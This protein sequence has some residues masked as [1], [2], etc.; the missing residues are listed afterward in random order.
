VEEQAQLKQWMGQLQ[1][2]AAE[3]RARID[4]ELARQE[5]EEAA[6]PEPTTKRCPYCTEVIGIDAVKCKHC[7]EILDRRLREARLPLPPQRWSPGVAAV[8]SLIWPGLG[9]MYKA[10]VFGGF[11]WMFVIWAAYLSGCCS[12]GIGSIVGFFLHVICIFDAA[13]GGDY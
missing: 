13:S 12:M 3:E 1:T 2:A 10:Q 4:A 7:G 5:A 11:V 9:Q 8:L 6:R